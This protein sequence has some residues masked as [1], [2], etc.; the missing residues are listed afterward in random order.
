[1]NT[2]VLLIAAGCLI[3]MLIIAII[4]LWLRNVNIVHKIAF[5]FQAIDNGDYAFRFSEGSSDNR[6]INATLN[7][8]KEILQHARDEQIEKEKYFE[9]VLNAVDTGVMVVDAERG[10][11]LRCN[12][13]A[14]K[15]LK[16]DAITHINQVKDQINNFSVHETTATINHK[17]VNIVTVSDIYNELTNQEIDA[18]VRLISVMTHEIMNTLTPVISLSE[19]LLPTATGEQQKGIETIFQT[20]RDLVKFVGNYRKFTHVPTP[21]PKLFYVKP[22]LDRMALQVQPLVEKGVTISINCQPKDLLVY[23]DESLIARVVSNLLKNAAEATVTGQHIGLHAFSD[24][25]E[26]VV[27]DV[28]DDGSPIPSDVAPH[29]FIPFFTTKNEGSGIGL[30]LSRQI[31]RMSNGSLVLLPYDD[32]KITTFR[33]RL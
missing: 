10:L 24:S 15:L 5:L 12:A 16:R 2:T 19:A 3:I 30:S 8:I 23:A 27:I 20:S 31:M 14:R 29:I 4:L 9:L 18:W 21:K 13:A 28:T 7:R 25:D 33:L 32:N 6:F 1:M 26:S 11:V 17:R 22:F